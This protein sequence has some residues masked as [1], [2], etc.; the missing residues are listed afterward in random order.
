MVS[1]ETTSPQQHRAS[2]VFAG[3]ADRETLLRVCCSTADLTSNTLLVTDY[4]S[5]R[6]P[7]PA[8]MKYY[9]PL[10]GKKPNIGG[11]SMYRK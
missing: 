9:L 8:Q 3:D 6:P 10:K 1:N 2:G 11:H 7:K 4:T 5:T